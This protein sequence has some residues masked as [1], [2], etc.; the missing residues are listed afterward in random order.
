[1]DRKDMNSDYFDDVLVRMAYHSSAMDGNTISL[2]ETVSIILEG[3]I[4]TAGHSVREFYEI[5]NHRQAFAYMLD[6]VEEKSILSVKDVERFHSL[7][8]D[9]LQCAQMKSQLYQNI[10][11]G[12]NSRRVM[13]EETSFLLEE[14]I[15]DVNFY[16]KRHGD[17]IQV[18]AESHIQFEKMH[19]FNSGNGRVGRLMNM[20]LAISVIKVPILIMK[21]VKAVY[22]KCLIEEDVEGLT[23]ILRDSID[24]ER[25][26]M[27]Q[28]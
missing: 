20:F 28:F 12:T 14:W 22:M 16:L 18:I 17:P 26:R 9:R 1:M 13:S 6:L 4:I 10:I 2:P 5:D 23:A 21:D 8:M 27:M 7:L 3:S 15:K 19:P 11:Y 25:I 24:Y